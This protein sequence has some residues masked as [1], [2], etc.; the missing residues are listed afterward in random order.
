[1]TVRQLSAHIC[2]VEESEDPPRV[3]QSDATQV[4]HMLLEHH[5]HRLEK[6][7][8]V[9]VEREIVRMGSDFQSALSVLAFVESTH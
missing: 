2:A 5:L 6:V 8:V 1:M 9:E 4:R 7:D 3:E